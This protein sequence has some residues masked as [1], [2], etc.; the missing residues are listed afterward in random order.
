MALSVRLIWNIFASYQTKFKLM[1]IKCASIHYCTSPSYTVSLCL[2]ALRK[3]LPPPLTAELLTSY[4]NSSHHLPT[5]RLPQHFYSWLLSCLGMGGATSES[6]WQ[7]LQGRIELDNLM[8]AM[9]A[10]KLFSSDIVGEV[11]ASYKAPPTCTTPCPCLKDHTETV[12]WAL[13]LVYEVNSLG[14]NY[15]LFSCCFLP[16]CTSCSV[17]YAI[18]CHDIA[19]VPNIFTFDPRQSSYYSIESDRL[20]VVF[21]VPSICIYTVPSSIHDPPPPVI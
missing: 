7:Q 20:Y 18:S 11:A 4:Y 12:L 2:R 8:A 17:R 9:P 15:I 14:F 5:S 21:L 13:H 16:C 1:V 10:L 3:L 6:S 19:K